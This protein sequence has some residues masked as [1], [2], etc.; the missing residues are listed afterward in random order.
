[1]IGYKVTCYVF[2]G[3][4]WSFKRVLQEREYKEVV[5]KGKTHNITFYRKNT[6]NVVTVRVVAI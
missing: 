4:S 1:V 3:C 6:R 2:E 5:L